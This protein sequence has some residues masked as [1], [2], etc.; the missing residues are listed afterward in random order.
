MRIIIVGCGIT[1]SELARRLISKKHDVTIIEQDE[2]TA[3]HAANRLD[4][5]VIHDAGNSSQVLIEAG[6]AK[7]DALVAVTD[8]DELNMIICGVAE[9]IAPDVLK[10]AR[11]RNENYVQSLHK[12]KD[13]TL[14]INFL[15]HPDEE[16]ANA[17]INT[18]E[19]GAV[20]EIISFHNS[21]YELS[22]FIVGKGSALDGIALYDIRK[23]IAVP[24]VVVSL[25]M[26]NK[27]VI[28]SGETILMAGTRISILTLP[29]H[30]SR[31]YELAGFKMQNIKKVALI[32]FGKVGRLITEGL[33]DK[34]KFGFFSKFL[35]LGSGMRWEFV[36]IDKDS[37][38]A[39]QAAAE[40]SNATV[41]NGDVT[42]EAFVEEISLDS[43]DLVIAATQ[44]Y[45]L[46][47]IT[48]AYLK[49]LG[50]P[51]IITLVQSAL[52]ENIAYK[53]GLDVAISFKDTVVDAIMS[54]LGGANV[55]GIHTMGNRQ[56][57][58]IELVIASNSEV[59]GKTLKEISKHG[60]FLILLV[61][62]EKGCTIPGGDTELAAGDK[63]VFIVQS[64]Q[65]DEIIE[66][67]GG[68][69]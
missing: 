5:M 31:F 46:N 39:K 36:I 6:I 26:R 2:E 23:I 25:E 27:H 14:G 49:T 33:A 1:G 69:K 37:A 34:P 15:V 38:S 30:I 65:S 11:V 52:M 54:H 8:S 55:T 66:F 24:F 60:I 28:P 63:L 59:I 9:G 13:R 51:K 62:N 50:V 21:P 32:G 3:R 20:S 61:T 29:E 53:I 12:T 35:G 67:L 43:F 40:F 41:Y 22:R 4:C 44:N 48:G 7:A 10:I 68:K 45:E 57:E 17:I 56:F 47:M 16:A 58:I 19:R 64:Q 18:V 42:D